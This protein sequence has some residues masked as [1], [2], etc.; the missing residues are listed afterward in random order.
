MT[1]QT[2]QQKTFVRNRIHSFIRNCSE[3][4]WSKLQIQKILEELPS[5]SKLQDIMNYMNKYERNFSESTVEYEKYNARITYPTQTKDVGFVINIFSK[6]NIYDMAEEVQDVMIENFGL[7]IPQD[8][9]ENA[10]AIQE[11]LENH[12]EYD[13][14][15]ITVN[16][17]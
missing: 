12:F 1:H 3:N 11:W 2:N 7:P 16:Q 4:G 14:V 17:L 10:E 6:E 5:K 9:I 13:E 15:I 8:S